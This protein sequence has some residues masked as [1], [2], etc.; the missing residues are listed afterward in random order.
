MAFSPI[1]SNQAISYVASRSA[2]RNSARE[3]LAGGSPVYYCPSYAS[4]SYSEGY[5]GPRYKYGYTYN[6]CPSP[7][8]TYNGNCTWWC[9]GRLYETIGT[10][11]D[12]YGNG[13][14]WYDKYRQEGGSTATDASNIQPGDI[15]CLTDGGKGHVMF[16][17]TVNDNFVTVSESAYSQRAIWNGMAC[18]VTSYSKS[19]IYAGASLNIYENM[20]TAAAYQTVVGI[21]KTGIPGPTPPTPP[22]PTV[23]LTIDIDPSGYTVT[24][25]GNEDYVDFTY[26][27]TV[28]GIPAGETIS[29]GN[30]YPGL[31]RVYNTGWTYSDYTVGGTTYRYAYKQQT[32]RYERESNG[33]YTTVKH[34]YFNISKSTGTVSTD[35]RMYITVKPKT[36][37]AILASRLTKR[38][39]RG[40]YH[41]EFHL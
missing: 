1:T 33:G 28:S 38:N 11:L 3:T 35:T 41:V 7:D 14:G 2:Y 29:G 24:M 30:T 8:N 25:N 36:F 6:N 9:W 15:I 18:L 21:L 40:R 27:I 13:A 5:G 26:N 17:E 4:T 31:S 32:L 39:K 10:A 22:T 20:D 34:M 12:G 19:D 37:L 23:N 16:V